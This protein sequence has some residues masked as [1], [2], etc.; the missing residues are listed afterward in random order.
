MRAI[1]VTICFL[2]IC[3]FSNAQK[4]TRLNEMIDESL[5][6]YLDW[7]DELSN[8]LDKNIKE[9]FPCI[10]LISLL[11]DIHFSEQLLN[12]NVKFVSLNN[13]Y[14]QKGLKRGKRYRFIITKIQLEDNH[15]IITVLGENVYII[16]KRHTQVEIID[17]GIFSYAYS[18]EKQ[19]W[20][21]IEKKFDGV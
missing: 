20:E 7:H 16:N 19:E 2:C 10:C 14:R 15:I 5:L 3:C 6:L 18:C 1:V 13:L 12:K 9:S 17:R 8:T 21:L 4:N 11:D